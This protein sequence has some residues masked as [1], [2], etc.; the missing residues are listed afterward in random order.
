MDILT[1]MFLYTCECFYESRIWF[2][3]AKILGQ[4]YKHFK[5]TRHCQID[6]ASLVMAQFVDFLKVEYVT[7]Y[8]QESVS[9]T[10]VRLETSLH[11][12]TNPAED[13]GINYRSENDRRHQLSEFQERWSL[14][15]M[16]IYEI[17]CLASICLLETALPFGTDLF[18]YWILVGSA[19]ASIASLSEDQQIYSS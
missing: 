7:G 16:N 5:F 14:N 1:H 12:R 4:R 2:L 3:E 8:T 6:A 17:V 9:L 15:D 11:V 19:C 18:N 13:R 10:A